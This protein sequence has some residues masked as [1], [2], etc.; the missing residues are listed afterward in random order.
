MANKKDLQD[1]QNYSRARLITAFTSG[2]PDG[3]EL[4]PKKGLT[5]VM[6]SIGLTAIMVLISV[7][8]GIISPGLPSDWSNNKLIVGKNTA[9]RFISVNG[10]LHPVINTTSAR[11]LIPSDEYR[12]ITVDDNELEGIPIGS[13]VGIVGAP[14]ILPNRSRL[15]SKFLVSCLDTERASTNNLITNDA[16]T[17]P[18]RSMGSGAGTK[19][20]YQHEWAGK[21]DRIQHDGEEHAEPCGEHAQRHLLYRSGLGY[22]CN[23]LSLRCC[24]QYARQLFVTVEE[25]TRLATK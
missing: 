22:A 12:V 8:Y 9:S 7:F 14:D 4:T 25:R 3:K 18:G 2:M 11:L 10:V 5:P 6:V 1:A 15:V 24:G 23:D 20:A 19:T 13:S 16:V 21:R 17:T